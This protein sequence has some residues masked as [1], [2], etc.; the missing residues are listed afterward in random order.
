MIKVKHR[1]INLFCATLFFYLHLSGG[2]R[3]LV[4]YQPIEDTHM[5]FFT[6]L[7]CADCGSDDIVSNGDNDCCAEC[8]SHN[9]EEIDSDDDEEPIKPLVT[10]FEGWKPIFGGKQ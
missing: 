7:I 8:G 4:L 9:Y 2:H 3:M 10:L 5:S 1:A 6:H